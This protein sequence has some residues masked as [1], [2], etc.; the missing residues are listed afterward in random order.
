VA[1]DPSEEMLSVLRASL[2]DVDARA[3][4]AEAIGLPDSSVGAITIGSAVHWFERPAADQE[5]ARVLRPG[6][7]VGV[8]Q[9][10]RDRS[11][12]WVAALEALVGER[13]STQRLQ[14]AEARR[15]PFDAAWFSPVTVA[16][17]PF[18]QPMDGE[19]LADLYASRS[20]VIALPP[21]ERAAVLDDIRN[22]ART[23]PDLA[24]HESF[25]LPYLT[26]VRRSYRVE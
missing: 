3:G 5:I 24:G 1:I 22:F 7:V 17:F 14:E 15:T 18:S 8:L 16:Q 19:R 25:E 10:E 23:H 21:A 6:G 26:I 9:N 20:Y 4:S 11:V 13:A 2:P 12:P